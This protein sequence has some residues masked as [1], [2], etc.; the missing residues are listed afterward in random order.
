MTRFSVKPNKRFSEFVATEYSSADSVWRFFGHRYSEHRSTDFERVS[1]ESLVFFRCLF[2]SALLLVRSGQRVG[3]IVSLFCLFLTQLDRTVSLW[4][5][6]GLSRP[7]SFSQLDLSLQH[8]LQS[9]LL[10]L[11]TF[12]ELLCCCC[13]GCCLRCSCCC[14]CSVASLR[15]VAVGGLFA[16]ISTRGSI[17]FVESRSSNIFD[18]VTGWILNCFG[19][20]RSVEFSRLLPRASWPDGTSRFDLDTRFSHI[21]L[22]D[23]A[24][25]ALGNSVFVFWKTSLRRKKREVKNMK[26]NYFCKPIR[27]KTFQ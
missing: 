12:S 17:N 13:C 6:S 11:C 23:W 27:L 21:L 5:T 22:T 2:N 8:K 15:G 7:G 14:C 20:I 19:L 18:L 1:R 26:A 25:K 9:V 16:E 24:F 4:L 10:F 3:P